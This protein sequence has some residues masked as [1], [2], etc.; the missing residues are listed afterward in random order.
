[1]TV[2]STPLL[3]PLLRLISIVGLKLIGWEAVGDEQKNGR[4]VL[5]GAPHT[6]NWDFL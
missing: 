1:M 4:F 6:S 3:T 5:I 2:F